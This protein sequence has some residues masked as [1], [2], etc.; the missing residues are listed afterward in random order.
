MTAGEGRAWDWTDD[1]GDVIVPAQ[2]AI[3]CYVNTAGNIV[4]RQ[5]GDAF[6]EDVWIWFDPQHAPAVAMAIL[7]AAGLDTTAFAPEPARAC[8]KPK[9]KDPT[10]AERQR[11]RR[12]RQREEP[13]ADIFDSADRDSTAA[14]PATP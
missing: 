13:T 4:L 1:A 11:R 10:A 14:N 5:Q 9:G 2:P 6:D 12:K 8:G 7:E 3:A